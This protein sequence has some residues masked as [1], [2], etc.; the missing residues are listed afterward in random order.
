L[1]VCDHSG[2][3]KG[4]KSGQGVSVEPLP[5][6][7]ALVVAGDAQVGTQGAPLWG[8]IRHRG[9]TQRVGVRAYVR[10]IDMLIQGSS[11]SPV[12]SSMQVVGMKQKAVVSN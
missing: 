12:K 8:Q 2:G 11:K 5:I 10:R 1:V 9:V 3:C 6:R 7:S 4:P